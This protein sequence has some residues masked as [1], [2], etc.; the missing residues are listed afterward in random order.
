MSLFTHSSLALLIACSLVLPADAAGAQNAPA[1]SLD[2]LVEQIRAEAST[3]A[4][5]DNDRIERFLAAHDRQKALLT[6]A[7]AARDTASRLAD[8]QRG[9]YESNEQL[10]AEKDR[11][12]AE[13]AGD[14]ADL[15]AIV[16]QSAVAASG[17]LR[18]S[19][20]S[21]EKPGRAEFLLE[22]G[23]S[24]R[25]PGITDVRAAW[26]ALLTEMNEAGK[27]TR[28]TAPVIAPT[29]EVTE[30]TVTR[31]GVFTVVSDGRFLR[32]LPETSQLIELPRQ[33]PARYQ[34]LAANLELAD[35]GIAPLAL[36]PSKGAILG[37]MVQSPDLL[38][39]IAQGGFIGYLILAIGAIG[40]AI[41]IE[42][43]IG[44]AIMRSRVTRASGREDPG[45]N[46]PVGRLLRAASQLEHRSAEKLGVRL[47]EQL[48]EES[49]R[50]HRGLPTVAVLATVSPLLGLLGTVT[51]MIETFQSITLFGTGD[52]K[53]MSGGISQALVTTELGLAVAIPLVLLHSLITGQAN[54]IVE[55]L[56]AYSSQLFTRYVDA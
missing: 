45:L 3:E 34:R 14:L 44:L 6:E 2:Q 24:D 42:R 46:N 19:V 50:L 9:E 8:R 13:T 17:V 55:R 25:S 30:R 22:L 26:L 23:K 51:G 28:F 48:A 31:A 10:L 18:S 49:A 40:L 1:R 47:D 56:S 39:E 36:D 29:G 54:G 33:P 16:R 20:V 21:L 4:R 53:L 41:V 43:T 15:F 11:Q 32:Y 27:V 37:L 52:P 5:H 35:S 38:E 7:K 12:L